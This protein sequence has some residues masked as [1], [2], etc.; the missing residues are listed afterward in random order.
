MRRTSTLALLAI[1]C[2]GMNGVLRL[3]AQTKAEPEMHFSGA[4]VPFDGSAAETTR[5]AR[6]QYRPAPALN[7][8][9]G[10]TT[11]RYYLGSTGSFRNFLEAGLIAGIPNLPSAPAQPQPP[12]NLNYATGKAYEEA[13]AAY[14]KGM[15]DWRRSSEVELRYRGRRLATGLATAETR[16]ALS[17]LVLPLAL[18]Q[19]PRYRPAS[20]EEAFA[21]RI[22]HAA[23]SLVVTR[24]YN[25]SL[26]PNYSKLL[27]TAGAAYL[28]SKV[29][30]KEFDVPQLQ[31]GRFVARYVGYSLAG[32]LATNVGRELVRTAIQPDIAMR[33]MHGESTQ[34]S[35]YPLSV[36]GKFVY[37][38]HSTYAL[39]NFAQAALIAGRPTVPNQPAFP[40]APAINNAQEELAYDAVLQ[41]YGRDVQAWRDNLEEDVRYHARRAIGGFGESETQ[42]F[43]TN[44]FLP[45]TLGMEPRYI[46]LGAGH[47]ARARMGSALGWIVIGRTDSGRKMVNLP[48][49]AG[50]AGAAFLAEQVYY[51]KLGTDRLERGSVTGRTIGFNLAADALGNILHELFSKPAR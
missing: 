36:G 10:G 43:L 17:N 38:A 11:V 33:A 21:Q 27:G 4:E 22:G 24:S 13:M 34:D 51:P 5:P 19:D 37:W 20:M 46:P 29:Y 12:A 48:L 8:S 23:A 3:E 1:L 25:G 9:H 14:G 39:R 44:F 6:D 31:T 7:G 26:Q 40:N 2:S 47:S 42:M 41:Q 45:V 32:D 49:L 35:Y 15:D 30:A 16:M 18:R 50:T 28:G